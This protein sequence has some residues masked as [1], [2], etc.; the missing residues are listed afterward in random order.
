MSETQRSDLHL[1]DSVAE[2][3]L[4]PAGNP[5]SIQILESLNI[6]YKDNPKVFIDAFKFKVDVIKDDILDVERNLQNNACTI[7]DIQECQKVFFSHLYFINLL[8]G[9]SNDPEEQQTV[10]DIVRY[11]KSVKRSSII[12]KTNSETVDAS[13][14]TTQGLLPMSTPGPLRQSFADLRVESENNE[15]RSL[16]RSSSEG[17][18][19]QN[20]DDNEIIVVQV[21]QNEIDNEYEPDKSGDY[22][23]DVPKHSTPIK[24]DVNHQSNRKSNVRFSKIND[25]RTKASVD[26]VK[27]PRSRSA[28]DPEQTWKFVSPKSNQIQE[29]SIIEDFKEI[30]KIIEIKLNEGMTDTEILALEKRKKNKLVDLKESIEKKSSKLPKHCN[31]DIQ[32]EAVKAFQAATK[33]LNDLNDLIE[34]RELHLESERKYTKPLELEKFEGHDDKIHDVYEFFRLF[35][36]VARGL[37]RDDKAYYLYAN[38]LSK[39]IQVEVKHIRNDFESMKKTLIKKYGNVNTLLSRKRM[40]I[41][42]ISIVHIRSPDVNKIKYIK[43]FIEQIEQIETLALLNTAD[44]PNIRNEIFGYSNILDIAKLLPEYLWRG[45]LSKYTEKTELLNEECLTGEG[46]FSVLLKFLKRELKGLEIT[47]EVTVGDVKKIDKQEKPKSGSFHHTDSKSILVGE[48]AKPKPKSNVKTVKKEN[49]EKSSESTERKDM[50][51]EN[52]YGAPCIAHNEVKTKVKDCI[53]GKCE[54]FLNMSPKKRHEAA[55]EKKVCELCLLYK[56]KKRQKKP[57]KCLLRKIFDQNI[58]CSE[59]GA[60]GEDRNILLCENHNNDSEEARAAVKQ[61]LPGCRDGLAATLMYIASTTFKINQEIN[62]SNVTPTRINENAFDVSTGQTIPKEDIAHKTRQAPQTE[63]MYPMQTLDING[64]HVLC[65][66]DSGAKGEAIKTSVAEKLK[67]TIIDPRPQS[68]TVAGGGIVHSN[69]PLYE[70]TIGPD[71]LN[72]YHTFSLLG[73]ETI[74]STVPKIDLT[75]VVSN[76]RKQLSSFPESKA[77]FPKE[78]G[79]SEI[80]LIIGIQQSFLFPQLTH[81]FPCG[82][83]IWKSAIPDIYGSHL[84]LAG[85]CEAVK[86]ASSSFNQVAPSFFHSAYSVFR[87]I[88][89][90]VEPASNDVSTSYNSSKMIKEDLTK[91]T[92]IEEILTTSIEV[93]NDASRSG[94]YCDSKSDQSFMLLMETNEIYA[95]STVEILKKNKPPI[96]IERKLQEDEDIG[97][98]VDYRCSDCIGCKTCKES[99]TVRQTSIKEEAEEIL[100]EKSVEVD[101]ENKTSKIVY[102][103][104]TPPESYLSKLWGSNTNYKMALSIFKAQCNKSEDTRKSVIKFHE[105]LIAR[106]YV[107]RVSELPEE[108]RKLIDEASFLHYFCWRS[109]FKQSVSTPARLVVDPSVSGFNEI[110]AKGTNCLTNLFQLVIKWRSNKYCFT[111]DISKMYNSLELKPEMY[112]FSLYLFSESL[113]PKE[114]AEVWCNKTLMYG[115]RSAANQS[116]C[117]LKRTATLKKDEYPLAYTVIHE[118]TYMDDSS[119]GSNDE[120]ENEEIIN[121][122]E[123]LLPHGGFKLKVITKCKEKPSE[124]ASS[125]GESTTFAGYKW[126]PLR[127]VLMLNSSDMNFNAKRRGI[128]KANPFSIESKEDVKKLIGDRKL[129]R[130]ILLGKVLEVF[131]ICGIFEPL[132]ARL[133]LDLQLLR[134]YDYDADIPAD[135]RTKWID[136]LILIHEARYIE[137]ERALVPDAATNPNEIEILVLSDAASSIC[138]VGLYARF[139]LNDGTYSVQLLAGKSKTVDSTIPRNELSSCALAAQTAFTVVKALGD[140][141]VDVIFCTDSS[142]SLCWI[143][144]TDIKLKPF[145]NSRVRL[146]HHLVGK[147]RFYHISGAD[148]VSDILTRGNVTCEDISKNSR[149]QKGDDWMKLPFSEMPL[150]SYADIC[151]SMTPTEKEDL[152]KETHPTLPVMNLIDVQ[153]IEDD[154]VIDDELCNCCQEIT[155]IKY[156][157]E[158]HIMKFA[159]NLKKHEVII[160]KVK[161]KK[162]PNGNFVIDFVKHGF[163]KSFIQL[164]LIFRFISRLK[165]KWHKSKGI[166]HCTECSICGVI[167]SFKAKGL[168]NVY[169]ADNGKQV[170]QVFCSPLDFFIAWRFVCRIGTNEVQDYYKSK[171]S[172]LE[173]YTEVDEILHGAGRLTYTN[174]LVTEAND[175]QLFHQPDYFQPVFLSKSVLTYSLVMFVHWKVVPHSGIERTMSI[176]LRIIHVPKLRSIVKYIRETCPRCRY[177]LKK[178]YLPVT[179]S[180]SIYSLMRAPPFFACMIDIAGNFLSF[181]SV[182][183]RV[184]KTVYF[185]VQV[186]LITGAVS[187]GVMEDLTVSS[188]ILALS[189]SASRYGWSKYMIAD[190]QTSFKALENVNFSLKDLSGRLWT[191]QKLILDFS[192]PLAHNE[193]GRVESKVKALKEFLEKSEQLSKKHSVLEW[194]TIGLD[195]A[196][197]I[198]GLPICHNQDDRNAFGELGLICPNMYLIGCNNNHSPDRFAVIKNQSC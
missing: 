53:S 111:S 20:N 175:Y 166:E 176:V 191:K 60:N 121:Q 104:T 15:Q 4:D 100:I 34:A 146:I 144:N 71:K 61:F 83:Q 5:I 101:I 94:I 102:P 128:K 109:V 10:K 30:S 156:E 161:E 182:K 180:Q 103:F 190:N 40:H 43:S 63:S 165:H 105:E 82:L 179:L 185:L 162:L 174:V 170:D 85:P 54:T 44:Y 150:R 19:N 120:Q 38:Y 72:D 145:V 168:M 178:H 69:S 58:I 45:F 160:N 93:N 140:R 129:T 173:E 123:S 198:N 77:V 139:K 79:G 86:K 119:G 36:I 135:L 184:S 27:K 143:V 1:P 97:C 28:I 187:I 89:Y 107:I 192:T 39:D 95:D 65:L 41:K 64:H 68:F 67:F 73:M 108:E 23:D 12:F 6:Q 37:S 84:I 87:N 141:V 118:Q 66:Y 51:T 133:K 55:V 188:V 7:D 137:V 186:C 124:K 88:Q 172:K 142:I 155:D 22:D 78:I 112:R 33:W 91:L 96:I 196:S 31:P 80:G 8:I 32:D 181:D 134:N 98:K 70:C 116:T 159:P 3:E 35:S 189:R 169:S 177:L 195:I 13:R 56:C 9:L 130:R 2:K 122:V 42:Q 48:K 106:G 167:T 157:N 110:L 24:K 81:I 62:T 90:Y 171:P 21:H 149:W 59:C 125:D 50:D 52:Y 11:L 17:S 163:E 138:G 14:F 117:A 46:T 127:D 49:K 153:E 136:N 131:D 132:K 147:D 74:S 183:Q 154:P 151:S 76:A 193:H 114:D 75:E 18:L 16:E 152:K 99:E 194:E 57:G 29:I 158:C 126:L 115:L 25:P 92:P 148:N 47:K 197:T 113:D 26:P 164:A